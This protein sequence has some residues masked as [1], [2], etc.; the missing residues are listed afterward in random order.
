MTR[1]LENMLKDLIDGVSDDDDKKAALDLHES[2][3]QAGKK[4]TARADAAQD[5]ADEAKRL[6]RRSG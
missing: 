2:A 3:N 5:L 1:Q 4:A 6:A